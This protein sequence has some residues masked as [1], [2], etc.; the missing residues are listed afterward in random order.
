MTLEELVPA[1]HLLRE[2]GATIDFRF[3]RERVAH[4]YCPDNGRLTLAARRSRSRLEVEASGTR[5]DAGYYTAGIAQGLTE[6]RIE[7]VIGYSRPTHCEG[8]LRKRDFR[9]DPERDGYCCPQG[10]LSSYRATNREGCR[11]HHSPP[12]H[13]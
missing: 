13:G 8:F 9:F 10:Q 3:S 11:Q 4:L 12:H 1:D 7:G 5:S 6:R 2:I